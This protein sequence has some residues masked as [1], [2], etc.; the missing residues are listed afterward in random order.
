MGSKIDGS[1]TTGQLPGLLCQR[2]DCQ[3]QN[4]MTPFLPGR[5]KYFHL[6]PISLHLQSR[7]R[8]RDGSR[9]NAV[10]DELTEVENSNNASRFPRPR[11]RHSSFGVHGRYVLLLL[12]NIMTAP[13]KLWF[14]WPLVGWGVAVLGHAFA[15]M[16]ASKSV[17]GP[18]TEQAGMTI[19]ATEI[20]EHARRLWEA[21]GAKAIAE[22][23]QK[24]GAFEKAGD[25]EAGANLAPH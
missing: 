21:H 14:Y 18:V 22:A 23:A 25:E 24:A 19:K 20:E 16:R 3:Q 6:T 17:D 1:S 2:I 11:L 5:C 9:S 13:N 8:R 15:V 12:I 4:G 7:D 10:P